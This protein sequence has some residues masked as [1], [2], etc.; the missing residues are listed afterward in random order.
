MP[1]LPEYTRPPVVAALA[2]AYKESRLA[3]AVER[4]HRRSEKKIRRILAEQDEISVE[5]GGGKRPGGNGWVRLDLVWQCDVYWN[6]SRG[7]PFP[8][9]RVKQIYSSHFFEHL[10]FNQGQAML[11]ECLRVLVRGG[12]LSVCVP[13]A[14]PYLE[15]YCSGK[16]MDKEKF[17]TWAP[18]WN[19]TTEI[20]YVNYTAYMD[21]DHQYMFDEENLLAVLSKA[22]FRNARPREFDPTLDREERDYESIYALAEK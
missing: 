7:L 21:G 5:L 4:T 20:D 9:S 13:S 22:G 17:I 12:T 6:L 3:Y 19:D 15:A 18:A 2:A 8:D 11:K 1:D 10:T 14:R 16:G